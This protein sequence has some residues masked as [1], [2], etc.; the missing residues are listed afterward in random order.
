[1]TEIGGVDYSPEGINAVRN[2][3]IVMRD[4][5]LGG[6]Y[7][8]HA[9]LLTHT[10]AYLHDYAENVSPVEIRGETVG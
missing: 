8:D 1:M 6:A 9:V 4:A 3:L 2:E 5:A 7:F 10:I